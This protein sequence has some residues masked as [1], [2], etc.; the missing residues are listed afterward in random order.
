MKEEETEFEIDFSLQQIC[1]KFNKQG[2]K[3]ML[4]N[5]CELG[6]D[7]NIKLTHENEDTKKIMNEVLSD[8]RLGSR[9]SRS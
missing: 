1:K 6:L 8:G 3:G 4:V 9:V 5:T 7:L 2:L